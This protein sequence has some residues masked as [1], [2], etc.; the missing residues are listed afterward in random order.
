MK[1]LLQMFETL[2]RRNDAR[3]W[4]VGDILVAAFAYSARFVDFYRITK[5]SGA[6]IWVEHLKEKIVSDDGY[7]QNG[8]CVPD[9]DAP[10]KPVSKG[11][12]IRK[13]GSCRVDNRYT[14]VWDGKPEDFYTD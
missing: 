14:Y 13:D 9:E 11:F 10:A 8:T 1:S 2:D 5:V 3:T 4:R 7:G 6:T 12:R